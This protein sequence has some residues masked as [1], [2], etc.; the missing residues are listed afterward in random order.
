MLAWKTLPPQCHTAR[1]RVLYLPTFGGIWH[2]EE[3]VE[4]TYRPAI[5]LVL[6][7]ASVGGLCYCWYHKTSAQT[8]F[9]FGCTIHSSVAHLLCVQHTL[10]V[11]DVTRSE[12][13]V[14]F[15]VS[16]T[17]YTTSD[18]HTYRHTKTK[19]YIYISI[20]GT[21]ST[22]TAVGGD[23]HTHACIHGYIDRCQHTRSPMVEHSTTGFVISSPR[24]LLRVTHRDT[25]CNMR[26]GGQATGGNVFGSGLRSSAHPYSLTI[27]RLFGPIVLLGVF[28]IQ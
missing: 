13:L 4:D 22:T 19:K 16:Y 7:S 17:T 14:F 11:T 12:L 10:H 24:H 18:P 15:Y 25:S 9:H 23:Q 1:N 2:A 5:G 26:N 27:K 3:Q 8:W 28:T 20:S 6:V 21:I